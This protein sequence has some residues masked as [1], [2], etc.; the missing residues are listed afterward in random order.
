M[1]QLTF[2]NQQLLFVKVPTGLS[3]RV[4]F[5]GSDKE[6][7]GTIQKE[8][9]KVSTTIDDE[10]LRELVGWEISKYYEKGTFYWDNPKDCFVNRMEFYDLPINE[11]DKYVVLLL[12]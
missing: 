6:Y 4:Y 8:N 1:K 3:P 5:D 7:L 10:V 9:G 2:N 11:G 12:K